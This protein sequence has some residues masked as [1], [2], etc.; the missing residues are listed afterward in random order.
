MQYKNEGHFV[1]KNGIIVFFYF[2]KYNYPLLT[3]RLCSFDILTLA[4]VKFQLFSRYCFGFFP[5]L[6]LKILRK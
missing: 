4:S 1:H 5:V 2:L 3:I 6:S